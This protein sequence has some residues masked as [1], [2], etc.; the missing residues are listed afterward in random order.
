VNLEEKMNY[1]LDEEVLF[2]NRLMKVWDYSLRS[3]K[4]T[5]VYEK[6]GEQHE[7]QVREEEISKEV[8][9]CISYHSRQVARLIP[10]ANWEYNQ[11]GNGYSI[12]RD[13]GKNLVKAYQ[14]G[15]LY[16]PEFLNCLIE[17][18]RSEVKK[19]IDNN[20]LFV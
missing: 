18:L 5:L 2:N 15:L 14:L 13:L 3:N 1:K 11:S 9:E 8:R 19:R 17:D 6:D 7:I 16:S 4:Y 12:Q 10:S 20:S